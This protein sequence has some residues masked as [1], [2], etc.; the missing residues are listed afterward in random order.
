MH[1]CGSQQKWAGVR[2][3]R[4]DTHQSIQVCNSAYQRLHCITL[5]PRHR[6]EGNAAAQQ[7]LLRRYCSNAAAR[8]VTTRSD[9][10]TAVIGR[11]NPCP[12]GAGF[13]SVLPYVIMWPQMTFQADP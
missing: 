3:S 13:R 7:I 5:S 9:A 2:C 11:H 8:P 10:A 6:S 1:T 4:P 12:T